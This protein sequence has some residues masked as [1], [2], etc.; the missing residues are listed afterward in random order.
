MT[1]WPDKQIVGPDGASVNRPDAAPPCHHE[2]D[3]FGNCEYCG[4]NR[5]V[6]PPSSDAA[7]PEWQTITDADRKLYPHHTDG[8][9]QGIKLVAGIPTKELVVLLKDATK[10]EALRL[11]LGEST[12]PNWIDGQVAEEL[13]NRGEIDEEGLD[14]GCTD[15]A[16]PEDAP[17]GPQWE[18]WI[19]GGC[20]RVGHII[21]GDSFDFR[22]MTEKQAI[23]VCDALNLNRLKGDKA[24]G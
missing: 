3:D 14:R 17:E 16:H 18:V 21:D 15:D 8:A 22:R 23:A 19:H 12:N 7:Q 11:R 9:I 4:K 1:T 24:D 13:Y 5:F 2:Y 6:A 20:F 10:R